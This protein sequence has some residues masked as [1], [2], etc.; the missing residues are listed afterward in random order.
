MSIQYKMISRKDNLNPEGK[1]K[2]GFYPQVVRWRT[3]RM[4]ELSDM[5][6][7]GTTLGRM[8]VEASLRMVLERIER[9]LLAGNHVCLDEFGT[10]SLT[11]ECRYVE[12]P[13]EI[14]AESVKVKRVVFNPSKTLTARMKT[15]QFIRA[16]SK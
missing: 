5:V 2:A 1:K 7:T 14:R 4:R 8:E 13:D 3:I 16:V 10:F 12:S 15:G 11:A 6:S 9:E